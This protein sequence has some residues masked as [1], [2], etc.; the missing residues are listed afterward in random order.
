[1]VPKPSGGKVVTEEQSRQELIVEKRTKWQAEQQAKRH[2]RLQGLWMS[3]FGFAVI[4]LGLVLFGDHVSKGR[5]MIILLGFAV[6]AF[7]IYYLVTGQK[8][9]EDPSSRASSLWHCFLPTDG[10]LRR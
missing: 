5:V 1:M 10:A 6:S 2:N 4:S 8:M 3:L 7:G 9:P